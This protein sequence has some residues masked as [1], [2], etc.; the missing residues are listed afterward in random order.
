MLIHAKLRPIDIDQ[1]RG[2]S[3]Q[4]S[5]CAQ[6]IDYDAEIYVDGKLAIA[7]KHHLDDPALE[8]LRA[9]LSKVPYNI[10]T[11]SSGMRSTSRIFGY[12]PRLAIKNQPCR[13]TSLAYDS[14]SEHK[15]L[16]QMAR[17]VEGYYRQVNPKLYER[18]SSLSNQN[19]DGKWKL[20]E[21]CFTS[22][23]AN[24]CNPLKYHFDSGNYVGVWS[25]MIV[26]KKDISGGKLAIPELDMTLECGD[27]S[28]V[29][30]DGQGLLH[31]V[32]PIH[33]KKPE[34]RRFSV[35]YYSLKGMWKCLGVDDEVDRLREI[36]TRIE[37]TKRDVS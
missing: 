19:L 18:H 3:A 29:L 23:I 37:R 10:S 13:V 8:V 9:N 4:E 11:R 5:D 1:Y 21:T 32:T 20:E 35:V 14:P 27:R 22:G 17:V 31:G 25:G 36:R 34:G 12:A 28:L 30:F 6:L 2:K 16:C 15:V 7:Y 26:L 24:D 33:K